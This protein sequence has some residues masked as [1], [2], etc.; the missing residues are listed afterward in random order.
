M[1]EWIHKMW[2]IHTIEYYSTFKRKEILTAATI[3]M[4]LEDMML[5]ISQSL[6]DK[7]MIPLI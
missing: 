1:D 2:H 6:K 5:K 7:Y 3:W 4:K